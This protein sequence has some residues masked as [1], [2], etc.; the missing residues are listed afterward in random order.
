MLVGWRRNRPAQD[1]W[2][3]PG[4]RIGKDERI[5]AAFARLTLDELGVALPFDTARF[6][7]VFEHLYPDNFAGEDGYGTH[8]VVLAYETVVTTPLPLPEAQHARYRWM[9]DAELLADAEVHPNTRA[10]V[11]PAA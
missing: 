9:T 3:V 8:Y 2:F 1:A 5:A 6:L 4:G 11:P 10:Y 7:G